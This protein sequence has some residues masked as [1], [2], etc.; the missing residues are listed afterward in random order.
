ME[1]QPLYYAERLKLLNP[2]GDVGIVTLWSLTE[3]VYGVLAKAGVDLEPQTSRIAVIANLYG[4]GLPHMLRNLLH[5]P[6]I[7][8]IVICGSN[9]S[10][11]REALLN[12]FEKGLEEELFLGVSSFRIAGTARIIDGEVRP[13]HFPLKPSFAVFGEHI[14]D[15]A[16]GSGIRDYIAGLPATSAGG[17]SRI[18]PPPVP[19]PLITRFPSHP[20][21][22][23]IHRA[24]PTEA[25]RELV[26]R[27]HRFGHRNKVRKST[28]TE[29]RVE[30]LNV[31]AV[32]DE[33][34]EEPEDVV[35]RA[36]F[37][38]E[39]FREYQRRILDPVLPAGV[40][41]TYGNLFRMGLDA[42]PMDTFTAIA[43]K[44][45]QD[46]ESR[47]GYA[48]SWS[49]R[50][51][52][53][54]GK[55]RPCLV[56]LFFRRFEDKLT[57]TAT[58]RVHNGMDGWLENF[59]GLIAIQRF[60]GEYAGIEP[61]PITVVSHS[62]SLDPAALER[63]KRIVAE[64][65]TDD[66]IDLETGKRELRFDPNGAFTVTFDRST[67]EL[68]AEHSLQGMKLGEYRGKTAEHIE[69]QIVRDLAVSV[70]S[71]AFYLGRELAR[72]EQ[73]MKKAKANA[74]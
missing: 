48:T 67:W 28:G 19:E 64:R 10:G 6:Q 60:V 8:H 31:H 70:I 36:G 45:K 51:H 27:L 3:S 9:T 59:Y 53:V 37:S 55:N 54:G 40:R 42:E 50:T 33:P 46:P 71:H 63:A 12:F 11:S 69:Q 72:K 23:V 21:L 68:V 18:D 49:N 61:G 34:R 17:L 65:T 20:A 24:T 41:Y 47:D 74:S 14:G 2:H 30:L 43:E 39:K 7:R 35:A 22:H 15:P 13:E 32:I 16:V 44:L 5:N 1:F 73:E 57:L 25:W 62:I 56:T 29:E 26:F 58:F 52:L 4:N 38:L 66:P